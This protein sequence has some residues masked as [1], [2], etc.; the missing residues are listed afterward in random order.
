MEGGKAAE[1]RAQSR[2]R[3][4]RIKTR[5][6]IWEI[7]MRSIHP[8]KCTNSTSLS[9]LPLWS[10][11]TQEGFH[12]LFP[13]CSFADFPFLLEILYTT[14]SSR[15]ESSLNSAGLT[16]ANQHI[17]TDNVYIHVFPLGCLWSSWTLKSCLFITSTVFCKILTWFNTTWQTASSGSFCLRDAE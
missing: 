1:W 13:P 7:T 6:L 17:F 9:G 10:M 2:S 16:S 15:K 8:S 4:D 14:Q 3:P 11:D 5:A 12:L